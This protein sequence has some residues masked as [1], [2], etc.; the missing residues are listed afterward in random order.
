MELPAFVNPA[1]F[2]IDIAAIDNRTP[3][4][5][6]VSTER[7]EGL[8]AAW[9]EQSAVFFGGKD[10]KSDVSKGR[11][12]DPTTPSGRRSAFGRQV[13]VLTARTWKVTYRDSMGMSGSIVEAIGMGVMTGWVFLQLGSDQAGIRSRE[14]AL[15]SASALQGYL[16]LMYETYRLSIDI[17]LF[18]REHGEGVVGVVPFLLSRRLARFL[19]EDLPVPFLYSII[20]YWMVGFR[21]DAGQFFTFFAIVLL[22][23]YIAVTFATC[24]IAA[25]RNFAGASVIA[26]LG[27]TVQ[28][29]ACGYFIQSNT[30]PVYVRWLKWTAYVFYAFGA[31]CSNEFEGHFY[32][33]PLPGGESNPA[34]AQ[35][36]GAYIIDSLGLP[37]NWVVRPI[38]I[39]FSF[40]VMFSVLAGR[41][42]TSL[43]AK[44][45]FQRDLCPMSGLWM[46]D[47]TSLRLIW[48]RGIF[49]VKSCLRR[50]FCILLRSRF[51][52]AC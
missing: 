27:Y 11:P 40:S 13:R 20:F 32:D 9:R 2:V 47:S 15:Y 19:M 43:L 37:H 8:Q 12:S 28:S 7:V 46:L 45:R 33:C 42:A 49:G 29:L 14:G 48:R 10:E 52:R 3:E 31:L 23:H 50:R 24:C 25:V 30:I 21:A 38:V 34:C 17:E 51:T 16:I 41:I 26:N 18:D 44:R 22:S 39:L 4:L 36:T 6:A 1:E 35:Y 5:E